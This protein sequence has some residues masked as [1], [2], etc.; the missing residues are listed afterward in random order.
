MRDSGLVI[1]RVY[2]KLLRLS[3]LIEETYDLIAIMIYF[4]K[5]RLVLNEKEEK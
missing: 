5:F 2:F 3:R 4:E 1:L